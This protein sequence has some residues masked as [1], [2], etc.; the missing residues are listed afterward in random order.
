MY[1]N[2]LIFFFY[3][4]QRLISLNKF[5]LKLLISKCLTTSNTPNIASMLS[6][7]YGYFIRLVTWVFHSKVLK[8]SKL[9]IN[10]CYNSCILNICIA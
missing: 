5:I 8:K 1:K 4:E 3:N 2:F 6:R 9:D 7:F 10:I